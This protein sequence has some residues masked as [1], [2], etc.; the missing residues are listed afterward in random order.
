MSNLSRLVVVAA[1]ALAAAGCGDTILNT[2]APIITPIPTARSHTIEFR[3]S[4][5][6]TAARIRYS[7]PVDGLTQVLT[8]LPYI[9]DV[10]TTQA[11]L[12]LSLDV[13]PIAYPFLITAPFLSAQITV[14]GALFREASSSDTA[15][16]TLSVNGT[17]RASP[18]ER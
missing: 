7:N 13:T 10:A 17:W 11:T 16:N 2:P 15:L 8:G 4:G 9:V 1:L 12:F 5:N 6:A 18:D 14:D 3:V